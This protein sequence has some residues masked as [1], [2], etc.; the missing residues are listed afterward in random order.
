M[1]KLMNY[2]KPYWLSILA[3]LIL[4]FVQANFDLA[5]PDYMS[6]IVNEGIQQRGIDSP[7]PRV[8]S[9][10]GFIQLHRVLNDTESSL[11]VRVYR[12]VSRD[13]VRDVPLKLE[14]TEK[15]NSNVYVL[16]PVSKAEQT[17]LEQ[18]IARSLSVITLMQKMPAGMG[19]NREAPS[20]SISEMDVS[21]MQKKAD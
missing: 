20:N 12:K 9:E 19:Q 4:L 2:L 8:L 3:V 7:V 21:Q 1:L 10:T 14:N 18:I 15:T 11:V 16:G 5:L 13:Q 6:R 17:E